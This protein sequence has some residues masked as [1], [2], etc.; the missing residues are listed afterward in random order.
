MNNILIAIVVG[1]IVGGLAALF[2][3]LLSGRR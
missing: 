1:G 3:L 2:V